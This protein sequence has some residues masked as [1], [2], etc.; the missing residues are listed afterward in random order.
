MRSRRGLLSA[1]TAS[2]TPAEAPAEYE[3]VPAQPR[4][5]NFQQFNQALLDL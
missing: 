2:E 1:V 4:H 3:T 5:L